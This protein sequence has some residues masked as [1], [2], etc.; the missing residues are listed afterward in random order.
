MKVSLNWIKDFVDFDT[1][2]KT[3]AD[4]MTAT[5]TKVEGYEILGEDIQNVVVGRIDSTEKH[6]DA[7]RLTICS[8]S[9][10]NQPPLM[11]SFPHSSHFHGRFPKSTHHNG[12]TSTHPF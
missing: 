12:I 11:L 2:A 3:Y 7:D 5:G 1:D 4:V 6:P 10:G 9:V 8:V